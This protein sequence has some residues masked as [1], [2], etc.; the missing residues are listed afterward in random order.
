[1]RALAR[2]RTAPVSL[3]LVGLAAL[4]VAGCAGARGTSGGATM[5]YLDT[6]RRLQAEG[7]PFAPGSEAL[8]MKRMAR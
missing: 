4:A 7:A 2:L 3:A 5:E 8:P 1:M 6:W